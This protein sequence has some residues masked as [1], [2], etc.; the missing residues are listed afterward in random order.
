M[1]LPTGA[2][3]LPKTASPSAHEIDHSHGERRDR[4]ARAKIGRREAR[5]ERGFL[6]RE[7]H[8][9]VR[10]A[11]KLCIRTHLDEVR[12]P[13]ATMVKASAC[14]ATSAPVVTVTGRVPRVAFRATTMTVWA[15][16]GEMI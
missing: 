11:L 4:N 15:F 13:R 16:S 10:A 6:S 9:Q 2:T 3:K 1:R 8:A 12:W 5:R 14:L 7:A